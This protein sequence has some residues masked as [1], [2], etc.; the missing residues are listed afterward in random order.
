MLLA[1]SV[2]L[3]KRVDQIV[4]LCLLL[5]GHFFL[6]SGYDPHTN[7]LIPSID[8]R[9]YVPFPLDIRQCSSQVTALFFCCFTDAAPS[10]YGAYLGQG[11]QSISKLSRRHL[12]R[13]LPPESLRESRRAEFG[14][15]GVPYPAA[16]YRGYVKVVVDLAHDVLLTLRAKHLGK[17]LGDQPENSAF[18]TDL[19]VQC[20]CL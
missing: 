15:D 13:E 8:P 7:F 14:A 17:S 6:L 2:L 3:Q 19:E 12:R 5:F 10:A 4:A 16:G 11:T 9:R 18:E 1:D 20:P